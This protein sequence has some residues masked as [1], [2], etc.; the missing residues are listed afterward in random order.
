[1][2]EVLSDPELRCDYSTLVHGEQQFRYLRAIRPGDQV[3]LR[4]RIMGIEDKRSGQVLRVRQQL[5]IGGEPA[6]E[7]QSVAFIRGSGPL[8]AKTATGRD[9]GQGWAA[10]NEPDLSAILAR[11]VTHITSQHAQQYAQASGDHNPIHLDRDVARAAGFDDV[12]LH[13]TCTLAFAVQAVVDGLLECDPQRLKSVSVR[14]SGPVVIGDCVTTEI[15]DAGPGRIAFESRNSAGR[16]L[17][18]NGLVEC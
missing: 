14:F 1:M 5:L 4:G 15:R 3:D 6:V 2:P 11:Q 10:A 13:G 17:L 18:S 7:G 8:P 9:N 12:I 16:V